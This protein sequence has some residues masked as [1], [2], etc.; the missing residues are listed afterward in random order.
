MGFVLINKWLSLRNVF[1]LLVALLL[2]WIA[3]LVTLVG[4]V[5]TNLRDA[6][7]YFKHSWTLLQQGDQ[8]HSLDWAHKGQVNLQSALSITGS[9]F[10]KINQALPIIG[11]N[12][13]SI[14]GVIDSADTVVSEIA[15]PFL[16]SFAEFEVSPDLITVY[17]Q[18]SPGGEK[19]LEN[20]KR[21]LEN[22]ISNLTKLESLNSVSVIKNSIRSLCDIYTEMGSYFTSIKNNAD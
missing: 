19:L 10:W 9:G 7:G 11:P 1:V 22:E 17:L 5:K 16:T 3:V 2:F 15:I 20:D 12:L 21:L 18:S 4:T 8:K 6:E 14:S 13:I